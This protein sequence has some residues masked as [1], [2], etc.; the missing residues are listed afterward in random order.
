MFVQRVVKEYAGSCRQS[1]VDARVPAIER[2]VRFQLCNVKMVHVE[3]SF[4]IVNV[5]KN[6][7]GIW[8]GGHVV[9]ARHE[10]R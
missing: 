2:S 7:E 9:C 8:Q 3:R 4:P 5:A 10:R 1:R 6:L